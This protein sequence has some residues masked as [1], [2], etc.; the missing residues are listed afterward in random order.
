MLKRQHADDLD[1][2]PVPTHGDAL[3]VKVVEVEL[4]ALD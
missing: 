4:D 2:K 3:L 1:F